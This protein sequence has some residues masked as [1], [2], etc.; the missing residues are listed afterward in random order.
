MVVGS[1]SCGSD[2]GSSSVALSQGSL[3]EEIVLSM[4][5]IGVSSNMGLSTSTGMDV[6]KPFRDRKV[7]QS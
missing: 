7:S 6:T 2:M 3:D 4:E 1:A 5:E